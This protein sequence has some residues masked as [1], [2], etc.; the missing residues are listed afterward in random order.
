M[1]SRRVCSFL[2]AFLLSSQCLLAKSLLQIVEGLEWQSNHRGIS[3][4]VSPLR[5]LIE[6]TGDVKKAPPI[7]TQ[8]INRVSVHL[9][10]EKK[11]KDS[12][13]F[14]EKA[15]LY[16][17][18]YL[19]YARRGRRLHK[20]ADLF[21]KEVQSSLTAATALIEPLIILTMGIIVGGIILSICLPIFEINQLIQ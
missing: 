14:H 8:L 10:K 4:V 16:A 13:W 17:R 1:V 12:A 19:A 11:Y 7:L 9:E 21:D 20:T 15:S 2:I 18:S 6:R 5:R 3:S